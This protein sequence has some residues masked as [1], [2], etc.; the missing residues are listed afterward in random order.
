MTGQL[1][2]FD[3]QRAAAPT[4]KP[5]RRAKVHPFEKW[6]RDTGV[7]YVEVHAA[8]RALFPDVSVTPF[9]YL[10]Y[11]E[12][13]PNLL[14]LLHACPKDP[15]AEKM[16][17]WEKIFGAEFQAVFVC[18]RHGNDEWLALAL[19]DWRGNMRNARPLENLL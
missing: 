1:E 12:S 10:V 18:R 9:D 14:V 8:R 2:L 7:P 16:A 17:E 13:G 5:K 19:R 4:P 3:A 11:C 15:H 6:L